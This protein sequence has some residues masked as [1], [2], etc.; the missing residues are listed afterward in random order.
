MSTVEEHYAQ[1]LS[2][3]YVWMHGGFDEA[4]ARNR[5]FFAERD[6]SPAGA[7][8]AVDL[9]AGCGFQSIPLAERGFRVTAVDLDRKLLTELE[10][11]ANGLDIAVVQDDLMRFDTHTQAP[12]ELAVCMTDTLLHVHS[13]EHVQALFGKVARQLEPGGRFI[14]TFRD[15]TGELRELERFIPVRAD[16]A[17]VFTCFLEYEPQTVKVHD[18]VHV[19]EHEGWRLLKSFYRKLRLSR[20]DVDAELSK[21]G[22]S[23]INSTVEKGFVTV[24]ATK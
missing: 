11:H 8:R 3:V 7:G 22:F 20:E 5:A 1:V 2:D 17:T 19:R 23:N 12:L 18:L 10:A 14:V 16:D 4:L 24:I 6:V 21:A 9:G 15:L 13:R